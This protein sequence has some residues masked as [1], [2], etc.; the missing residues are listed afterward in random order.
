[1]IVLEGD[2]L[3]TGHPSQSQT[4]YTNKE[5][6]WGYRFRPCVEYDELAQKYI[7]NKKMFNETVKYEI[8]E[9][10]A[11]ELQLAVDE[12]GTKTEDGG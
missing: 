5:I 12:S 9:C 7:V 4:S 11:R 6:L 2:S 3:T 1:M 10:S 8:P